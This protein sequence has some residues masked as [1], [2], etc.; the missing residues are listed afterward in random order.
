M[1]QQIL[2]KM[3]KEAI[4]SMGDSNASS[5]PVARS[6]SVE[7]VS[8]S[9]YPL[10]KN[11][12]DIL[13]SSTGKKLDDFTMENVM[14]GKVGADDCRIAPETLEMQAQIAEG[15]GRAAFAQNLRR[16]SEL[17]AIP[18]DRILEIY[19][20]LRPYRSTKEELLDIANELENKYNAVI[21]AQLVKE[22]AKLYENRDRLK[23]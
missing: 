20:K 7:S 2:E 15:D 23:K 3:I 13:R 22:A 9:D 6:S 5:K 19:D 12:A 18:D 10:S 4:L 1:D 17:I 21:N 11:K 8:V 16:A 14:N